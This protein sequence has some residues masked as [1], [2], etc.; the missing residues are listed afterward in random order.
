MSKPFYVLGVTHPISWNN[1]ACLLKDGKLVAMA[2]EERFNRFKHAPRV[3]PIQA[4]QYCL[5]EAG[6]P[7]EDVDAIGIGWDQGA[8]WLP[9]F[10]LKR[11]NVGKH[12][13]RQL[14]FPVDGKRA[15]LVNHHVAHALSAF[16]SSGFEEANV[17]SL[18]ASGGYD[19]GLLGA[20]R[21]KDLEEFHRV[22][23]DS[24][25]GVLYGQFTRVLGFRPHSD[26]GKVMGLAAFG[27]PQGAFPFIDF[28]EG[29]PRI[30]R[31][32]MKRHLAK[33]PSR[34]WQEPLSQAHKD[35]AATLQWNFEKA[36]RQMAAWLHGKT[37]LRSVCLGG[38]CALNCSTNGKVLLEPFVDRIFVQPAAHDA[39][40]ALGAA[41]R[42]HVEVTGARPDFVLEHAYWG[43]SFSSAQVKTALDRALVKNCRKSSDLAGDV[44]ALLAEGKVVGWFQGRMEIGPRALGGR[45]ILA[46]PRR[47]EAKDHVNHR[48]K[49]REPWRPF[50]PSFLSESFAPY[51]EKPHPSPFMILAFQGKPGWIEK[52]PAA[53]HVDRTIRVQTVEKAAHPRYWAL[54]EAFAGRTGVPCLLNTSFNVA[55]QPIVCTP[56]DAISTF[57]ACG[58]DVLAIE[59]WLVFKD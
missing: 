47:I 14:P 42:V 1:A 54:I 46:D 3:A 55:G 41:F 10:D 19:S 6:I 5:G 38:G 35:L 57:F 24:S 31:E 18:D 27:T 4:I 33:L 59:D 20:G 15:R 2:E 21:G 17:I 43:P 16:Y 29:I 23:N 56:F 34:G 37:G 39:S 32:G 51:V 9:S 30:D 28:D 22:P 40:T 44:S 58:L 50:A 25:W 7:L 11:Y 12:Y 8:T 48:V 36:V 49:N 52:L 13:L 45:S 53:A 26:E